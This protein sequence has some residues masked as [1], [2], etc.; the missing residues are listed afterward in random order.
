[1][2]KVLKIG[3]KEYKLEYSIEASLYDSCATNVMNTLVATSGGTEKSVREMV[4]GMANIPSAAL[5]VFYAG[6]MQY[7]GNHSEGDG[8]VPNLETAKKLLIQFISEHKDDE[9]GNFYGVFS[10]CLEQMEEDGFFKLTGLETILDSINQTP[11]LKKSPKKPSDHQK[12][13]TAK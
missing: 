9:N 5:T 12:K 8:T 4:S 2:Y 11:K 13:V 10:M 7:H 6:L 1:M 3:D